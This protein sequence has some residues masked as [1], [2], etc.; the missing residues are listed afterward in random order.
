MAIHRNWDIHM[1][2]QDMSIDDFLKLEI[3][4]VNYS[5]MLFI[6]EKGFSKQV[7]DKIMKDWE[8][9]KSYRIDQVMEDRMFYV[10]NCDI[11][12]IDGKIHLFEKMFEHDDIK[13]ICI[14]GKP[15]NICQ[16]EEEKV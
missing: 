13:F 2:V 5:C 7:Y 1:I 3:D 8:L 15:G 10:E 12:T 14:I 4:D 11:Q 16:F 6:F 9:G